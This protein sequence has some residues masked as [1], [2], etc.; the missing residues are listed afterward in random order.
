MIWLIRLR[1][2]LSVCRA[3]TAILVREGTNRDI[4]YGIHIDSY[5]HI[6]CIVF[7]C[8][9]LHFFNFLYLK[10]S[11]HRVKA[12]WLFE[13]TLLEAPPL[14]QFVFILAVHA[15]VT[16]VRGKRKNYWVY[17]REWM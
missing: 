14:H 16:E 10:R 4:R 7:D 15:S 8:I 9:C 1:Q 2:I 3:Q 11:E 12:S 17:F 13:A 5:C 6:V